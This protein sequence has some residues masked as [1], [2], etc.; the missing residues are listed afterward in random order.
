[1]KGVERLIPWIDWVWLFVRCSNRSRGKEHS[2]K[3]AFLLSFDMQRH[4]NHN[5]IPNNFLEQ[6]VIIVWHAGCFYCLLLHM[7]S[8]TNRK[9]SALF[10]IDWAEW[11][12]SI[13]KNE[14]FENAEK[15]F[16]N[17]HLYFLCVYEFDS[18]SSNPPHLKAYTCI[19]H[20]NTSLRR[21]STYRRSKESE[22]RIYNPYNI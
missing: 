4:F 5:G 19:C 8:R 20:L 3:H 11:K 17:L 13:L 6:V 12:R 2:S 14:L 9:K 16:L 10:A 1:M 18:S 15:S 22:K 21:R 7:K